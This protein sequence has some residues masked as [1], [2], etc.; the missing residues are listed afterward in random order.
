[1]S[2]REFDLLL[3]PTVYSYVPVFSR[4]KKIVVIHDVI[5]ENFAHLTLPSYRARLFWK[6]KVA[7][8]RWQAD[9]IATVSDYSR[10]AIIRQFGIDPERIFVVG[11]ASDPIFR[12]LDQ[13]LPHPTAGI[14]WESPARERS[15]VYVGGFAPH[16]NLEALVARLCQ[17]LPGKRNL[18]T[19][20]WLWSVKYEKEVFHSYFGTIKKQVDSLGMADRDHLHRLSPG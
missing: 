9:A 11:E 15:V 5:A 13:S 8:G 4:A 17:S 19:C 18:P 3:F 6:A 1:M 2:R 7:L 14:V 12:G 20:A 16:K 10:Q